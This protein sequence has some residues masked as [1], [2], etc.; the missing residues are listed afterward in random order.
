MGPL[1]GVLTA[2]LDSTKGAV[3]FWL[4]RYLIP[5]PDWALII[6][7]FSILGHNHPFYLGF[8]GGKGTA[9]S[10]GLILFSL[11]FTRSIT[12]FIIL[13]LLFIRTVSVSPK[14]E[15]IK[16][17]R[18]I[19]RLLGFVLPLSY[20]L[21]G[22]ATAFRLAI[23]LLILFLFLDLL[24]FASAKFNV[25]FFE[26][27]DMFLKPKE[28]NFFSTTTFF[29]ISST[30][31]IYFFSLHVATIAITFALVGDMIAEIYGT[32][33]HKFVIGRKSLEGS[34]FG[35]VACFLVGLF[36]IAPLGVS[37]VFVIKG[38]FFAAVVE[39]SSQKIDDN[40]TLPFVTAFLLQ[41]F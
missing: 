35:F 8:R 38:A 26:K 39:F 1:W 30:L 37:L 31:A 12:A 15:F 22:Q 3:A 7:L 19:Y 28:K 13:V 40:L 32:A 27:L 16:P 6:S 18:K 4:V 14:L 33:Y 21:F 36:L 9:T 10:W 2:F 24:R 20:L 11:I 5:A 25:R 23:A 41:T 29:L 34:F 17:G